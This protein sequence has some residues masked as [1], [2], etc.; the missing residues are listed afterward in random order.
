MKSS[1][2]AQIASRGVVVP[3][4]VRL[5]RLVRLIH[6][7]HLL[8]LGERGD[9]VVVVLLLLLLLLLHET[10]AEADAEADWE[11]PVSGCLCGCMGGW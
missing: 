11:P 3:W 6:L 5:V 2:I 10:E 4:V 9:G 8:A 1:E 7:A